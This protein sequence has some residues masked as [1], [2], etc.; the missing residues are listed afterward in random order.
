MVILYGHY[1]NMNVYH[2]KNKDSFCSFY[3]IFEPKQLICVSFK[4][5][6]QSFQ[7]YYAFWCFSQSIKHIFL[8]FCHI[9]F[10][11]SFSPPAFVFFLDAPP[12]VDRHLGS[13]I[14]IN[15]SCDQM[16]LR[17]ESICCSQSLLRL[18]CATCRSSR[19]NER[20]CN[21]KKKWHRL[22]ERWVLQ[23]KNEYDVTGM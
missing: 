12:R 5:K 9:P 8:F 19:L 18:Y 17:F 11:L 7:N 22:H 2:L 3:S 1:V 23:S 15:L 21:K 10:H 20:P 16:A 14:I 13:I 4:R 6:A